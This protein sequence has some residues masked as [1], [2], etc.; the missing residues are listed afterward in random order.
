MN[1]PEFVATE[2]NVRSGQVLVR[3]LDGSTH[4]FPVHFYPKLA[5]APAKQLASVKLRVGGR[6]LRWED[7]DEDIWIADAVMGL[8]AVTGYWSLVTRHWSLGIGRRRAQTSQ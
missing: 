1:N 8:G 3:L 5:S 4:S 7:L 2:A 6:A